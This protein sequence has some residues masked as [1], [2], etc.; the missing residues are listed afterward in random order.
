MN[1]ICFSQLVLRFFTLL[2]FI[3][4]ASNS[5]AFMKVL[6]RLTE[7]PHWTK[8]TSKLG[9]KFKGIRNKLKRVKETKAVFASN[10]LFGSERT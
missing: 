4:L 9:K 3:A 6:T 10:T 8:Y 5:S 1:R 2:C 7:T